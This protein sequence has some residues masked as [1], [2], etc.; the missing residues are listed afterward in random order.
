MLLFM[1]RFLARVALAASAFSV[2]LAQSGRAQPRFEVASVKPAPPDA[3][4]ASMNGGPLPAGPFNQG[5][6]NPDRIAWSNTRL[7]RMIQVAY[8][9]PL[10][11]ISGPEWLNTTGYDIV[12]S[13]PP[14][15]S[16]S[17]FRLMLQNLLAERFKLAVHRGT[18]EVSGYVLE[19]AKRGPKIAKSPDAATRVAAAFDD[20]AK[21]NPKRDEALQYMA[22]RT[23]AFNAL[24]AIDENGF[25][26]PRAGNPYYP[27]G[28]AFEVTIVV[29]G[30]YRSTKLNAPIPEIAAFLGRLAG[31]PAEDR[32][33]LTGNYDMH[34]EFVP[35]P[36]PGTPAP[37]P[38]VAA[39][40]GPGV[41]DAVQQ[42][43][44]LKLT[45][46]KVPVETLVVDHAE[47]V[48]AEN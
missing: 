36:A 22:T 31:A 26:A 19:I 7:I 12:A 29:N 38:A 39:E 41:L 14:G 4:A 18:K 44:G 11:N 48:P 25:P 24:V 45:P 13:V 43:L 17:D 32:T 34:L 33:G 30:R 37:D 47:R 2:L 6:H 40:P 28:A 9:F 27:P 1:G 10:D 5:E 16:V 46:G 15:A 20:D 3:V 8:D 35:D 42:Q 23:A 21:P